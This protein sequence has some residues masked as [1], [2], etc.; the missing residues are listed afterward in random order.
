M[1]D[2]TVLRPQA[3]AAD[4]ERCCS[5]ALTYGFATVCINGWWVPL[6]VSILRGSPV[7]VCTVAGFPLGA[8][9]TSAKMAEAEIAIRS[10]AAEV[11]MVL[12]VGALKSRDL[13][14]VKTDIQGVAHVCHQGGAR[15]KVILETCLLT[16][17]EIAT[18]CVL[19][20][21]AGADFVKTS[22]GFSTGGATAAHVTLMSRIVAPDLGVKASGGIRTLDDFLQMAAAGATRI[23]A[24]SSVRIVE[25]LG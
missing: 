4:I 16:D 2:H 13:V 19:S 14:S 22:T 11:D 17:R 8:T 18:A 1:I 23:G 9:P 5:E 10:G 15:L 25:S 21:M 20:K 7:R 12:S 3:S 6:A 24:S